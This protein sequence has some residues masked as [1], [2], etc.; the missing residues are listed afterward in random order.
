MVSGYAK[1]KR[2]LVWLPIRV[3]FVCGCDQFLPCQHRQRGVVAG[4]RGFYDGSSDLYSIQPSEVEG[5]GDKEA[6]TDKQDIITAEFIVTAY[7]PC[8]ECS[9]GWGNSTAT[10]AIAKQGRTIAVDPKIIPYGTE[11]VIDGHTYV[12]E[13]CGGVIKGNKID[14]Y[15]ETHEETIKWGVQKKIVTILK[16]VI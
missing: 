4:W 7:C 15:F 16:E 13:D 2:F 12:A 8:Y 6:T 1:I 5:A 14:I 11:V 10:G 3:E 9:E